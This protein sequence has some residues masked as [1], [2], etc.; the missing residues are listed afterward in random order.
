MRTGVA[1]SINEKADI[2]IRLLHLSDHETAQA[3][4]DIGHS[5]TLV[6]LN[7]ETLSLRLRYRHPQ[8]KCLSGAN[9]GKPR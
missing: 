5:R 3:I 2:V 8:A 1:K 6:A 7:A 4:I 9:L